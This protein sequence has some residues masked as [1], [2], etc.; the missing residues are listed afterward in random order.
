MVCTPKDVESQQVIEN[1]SPLAV[2][3]VTGLQRRHPA[4]RKPRPVSTDDGAL[5]HTRVG[6]PGP[7]ALHEIG[8]NGRRVALRGPSTSKCEDYARVKMQRQTSQGPPDRHVTTPCQ[9]IHIDWAGW[10]PP[11]TATYESCSTPT[12]SQARCSH[13]SRLHIV[14]RRK[15]YVCS[16]TSS[17][18]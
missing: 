11:T 4:S 18:G 14:K 1:G 3:L 12:A 5:R 7:M 10:R 8:T 15:I 17:A 13:S 9:E 2:A 16:K 6:H